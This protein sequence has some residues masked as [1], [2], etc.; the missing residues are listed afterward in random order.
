MDSMD[1]GSD[2]LEPREWKDGGVTGTSKTKFRYH[3]AIAVAGLITL[4]GAL[5]VATAAW[6]LLPILLVPLAVTVWAWLAGTDAD[7]DGLV[8]RA[9]LGRRRIP[10]PS[11]AELGADARGRAYATLADGAAVPLP[12]VT[13]TDLPRLVAASGH[14][15]PT[16]TATPTATGE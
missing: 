6:Y 5:P 14:H 9:L 12:A 16:A 13:A 3:A 11:V 4:I 15:A 7:A 1:P 8:V 10:W 2:I